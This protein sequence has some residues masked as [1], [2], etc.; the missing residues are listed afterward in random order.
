MGVVRNDGRGLGVARPRG[1]DMD[2]F[3]MCVVWRRLSFV[4]VVLVMMAA[5]TGAASAQ[6]AVL[7]HNGQLHGCVACCG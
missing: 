5:R 3:G 7:S 1:F 2:R 4:M 6:A